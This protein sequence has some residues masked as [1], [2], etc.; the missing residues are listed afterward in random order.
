M[1]SKLL[2]T[3]LC[4]IDGFTVNVETDISNGMPGFDIVGLPDASVKESKERIRAAI[5]NTGLVMPSKRITVNLAPAGVKKEGSHFDAAIAL[6]ILVS[7]KEL[8]IPNP[9]NCVFIG[10]LSLDGEL[11]RINGALPMAIS[12]FQNGIKK[13]FLPKANEKE[14]SVI[15]G[16]EVYG[17]RSLKDVVMHFTNQSP[18]ERAV[19]SAESLFGAAESQSE[20]FAEVK[21]Q[22]FVKRALEVAAA[23]GH[24]I[25]MIGPPGSG[26]TMIAKRIPSILPKM[27]FSE[28]LEVTKIHSISGTLSESN[29]LITT[30]PFRHPHHT[31]S[32]VGLSGG[33]SNPRPGELS[34]AHNGVLFLDELPEFRRDALEVMRQPLED[35]E[36]TITRVGGTVT[37]PCN[38]MLVASMNPCPCGYYGD[39]VRRCSCTQ[40]QIHRYISKISGPLLDRIDLHVEVPALNYNEL[41]TIERGES[42]KDIRERVDKA[43]AIQT[44]RYKND[45]F[46]SNSRITA[47]AAEKYCKP[48]KEASELLRQAFET[49]GLS[50]RAYNRIL[51]VA[52]TIADLASAETIDTSHIA[53]AIQYRALDMKFF[54]KG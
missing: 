9:E 47:A 41:E 7:A 48:T 38:V 8:S 6:G 33:G 37:Y 29:P 28:A 17:A 50:A 3:A 1:F 22:L 32:S 18:I 10:E 52:R 20:D 5:K 30:R 25:L 35:G 31:V 16:I 39:S 42:S 27:S 13:I 43:R 49:L 53:E 34:L 46:Y 44:E 21:G 15:D 14:V 36:I 26:K 45:E 40:A 54:N 11:R 23:G 19:P 51:K 12:A 4:G 24:N 2:S